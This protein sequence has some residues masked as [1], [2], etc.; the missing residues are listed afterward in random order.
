MSI[1]PPEHNVHVRL[2]DPARNVLFAGGAENDVP[3]G[4]WLESVF[5]VRGAQLKA[6]PEVAELARKIHAAR[7]DRSH[8]SKPKA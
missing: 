6:D 7:T 1:H 5:M 8:L 4:I 3:H 2:S